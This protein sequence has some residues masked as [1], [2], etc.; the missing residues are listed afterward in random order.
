MALP[1]IESFRISTN[2]LDP[3]LNKYGIAHGFNPEIDTERLNHR[4]R[5]AN[6]YMRIQYSVLVNFLKQ[7]RVIDF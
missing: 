5:A 2:I 1:N 3:L 4:L 6:R 7:G